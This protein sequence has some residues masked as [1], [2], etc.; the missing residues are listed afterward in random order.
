M[1]RR[2][3]TLVEVLAALLLLAIVVP[4]ALRAL[5]TA[6]AL[7]QTADTQRREMQLAASKIQELT[8]GDLWQSS[9]SAGSFEDDPGYRWELATKS[10]T[11]SETTMR[12][13]E[14]TVYG[15]ARRGD[16]SFV[17]TT[18]VPEP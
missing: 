11:V 12:Q 3:F 8:I 7:E 18:L 5:R 17:L 4:V 10:V 1:K 13:L 9:D 16:R 15:P 6:T 2:P 14:V